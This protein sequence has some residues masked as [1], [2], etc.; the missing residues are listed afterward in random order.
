MR[1]LVNPTNDCIIGGYLDVLLADSQPVTVTVT[2]QQPIV[3]SVNDRYIIPFRGAISLDLLPQ[4]HS[5]AFAGTIGPSR[6]GSFT[7]GQT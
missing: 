1:W 4:I 3:D 5:V 6:E 2:Y 7:V